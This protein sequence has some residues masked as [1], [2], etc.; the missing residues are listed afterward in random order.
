MPVSVEVKYE[1]FNTWAGRIKII[2]VI[3]AFLC[4]ACCAPAFTSTQHWFLLVVALCFVGTVFLSFYHL[5]LDTYLK[6]FS[7]NWTKAEFWFTA[8][9]TFFYFTAF[10]AQLAEFSGIV[11]EKFQY[12]Y[13]AQVSA[14]VFAL[15][16]NVAYGVGTYFIYLEWKSAGE[17]AGGAAPATAAVP[18]I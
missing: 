15:F 16:N 6:A 9:A 13:D 3:L 17:A 11:N 18:P 14:G 8:A 7:V 10:T 1:Y 2:E 5:F 12:W 4:M